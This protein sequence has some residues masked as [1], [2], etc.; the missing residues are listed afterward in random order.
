VSAYPSYLSYMSHPLPSIP[1]F[2][3]CISPAPC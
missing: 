1:H 2:A 3:F